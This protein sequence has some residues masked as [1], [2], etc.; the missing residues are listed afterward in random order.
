[1]LFTRT[2]P[3]GIVLSTPFVVV[4]LFTHLMLNGSPL[5][6]I[7][8]A[9]IMVL[10][11]WQFRDAYQPMWRSSQALYRIYFLPDDEFF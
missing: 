5:F 9:A 10:F 6:R 7:L 4:I 3:M 2:A 8:M 1:M 11:A